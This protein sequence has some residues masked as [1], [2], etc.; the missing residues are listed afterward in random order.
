MSRWDI[1]MYENELLGSHGPTRN[2]QRTVEDV[3]YSP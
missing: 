2:V 3:P 1:G